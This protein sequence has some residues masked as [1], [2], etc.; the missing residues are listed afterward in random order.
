MGGGTLEV[1]CALLESRSQSAAAAARFE[2]GNKRKRGGFLSVWGLGRWVFRPG[3][4]RG[5]T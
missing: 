3:W 5:D 4:R 1:V 2:T